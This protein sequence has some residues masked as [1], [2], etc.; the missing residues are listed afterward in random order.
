MPSP[1][2]KRSA[3]VIGHDRLGL[4]P[5]RHWIA[6]EF[7]FFLHHQMLWL[8]RQYEDSGVHR[9]VEKA[10]LKVVQ[11][12]PPED[13]ELDLISILRKDPTSVAYR[14]HLVS[15]AV[16]ALT[17]DM[18][19]FLYEALSCFEK[20]KCT[21]AFSLLRKPLKEN[22]LFLAW[23]LGDE[24]NFLKRFDEITQ[25]LNGVSPE[26]RIKILAA[27]IEKLPVKDAFSADLLHDIIYSKAHARGFEPM[28]QR[29]S[30]LVTSQGRLL[31][32]ESLDLNLL[33]LDK[34]RRIA[35][36]RVCVPTLRPCVCRAGSA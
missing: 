11:A 3:G 31:K 34:R 14:H 17:S 22:L 21:V 9:S 8:L 6:H 12:L 30:H 23:L 2:P 32:T 28:W 29:A 20:R 33:F 7:C 5:P 19:H 13:R 10:F 36:P 4:I 1:N 25:A 24:A 15:H 16:F 18:L 27:A 26:A 35:G